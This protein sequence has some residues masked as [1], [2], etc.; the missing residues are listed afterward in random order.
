MVGCAQSEENTFFDKDSV[1]VNGTMPEAEP[2]DYAFSPTAETADFVQ[3]A[4]M[5]W[6]NATGLAICVQPKGIPVTLVEEIIMPDGNLARGGTRYIDCVPTLVRVASYAP[7]PYT[8]IAHEI[9]HVLSGKCKNP[10]AHTE[11]GI[12]QSPIIDD[13]IDSASLE[14][15]CNNTKCRWFEPEL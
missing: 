10:D 14:L 5:R 7:F 4:I 15:I 2:C 6:V 8:T 11:S 1:V 3:S 12:M 9:G 13:K